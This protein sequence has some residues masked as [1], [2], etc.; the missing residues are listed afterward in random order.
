ML[1]FKDFAS[2]FQEFDFHNIKTNLTV[3]NSFVKTNQ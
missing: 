3:Y 1:N 2:N